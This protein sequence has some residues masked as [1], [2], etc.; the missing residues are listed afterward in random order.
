MNEHRYAVTIEWTGDLGQQT[1][2]YDAYLRDYVVTAAGKPP[3]PASSD[4]HFRGDSTRYNPEDLL[5]ASLSGCHMLWYLHLCAQSGVRVL[6]YVDEAEGRMSVHGDSGR[7]TE[8]VLR[9]RVHI[10]DASTLQT[11][12]ALHERAH[13]ACYIAASV[14]FPVRHEPVVAVGPPPA[15][16]RHRP[17]K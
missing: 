10:V 9:P 7:F 8:V 15:G 1:A 17:R 11:A 4:P 3:V 2:A 16:S 5:V 12:A 14:N 13:Q 6:G